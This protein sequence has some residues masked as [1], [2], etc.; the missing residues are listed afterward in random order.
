[1][2]KCPICNVELIEDDTY[3]QS[4]DESFGMTATFNKIG[5]CPKCEKEYQWDICYDLENPLVIGLSE[6]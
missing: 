4:I 5:H 2:A 1:M 6:V 3:D